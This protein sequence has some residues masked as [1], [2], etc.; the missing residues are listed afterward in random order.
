M[1]LQPNTSSNDV[2]HDTPAHTERGEKPLK[3]FFLFSALLLIE[4]GYILWLRER[5]LLHAGSAWLPEMLLQ[6]PQL[7]GG[8]VVAIVAGHLAWSGL[9]LVLLIFHRRT[10]PAMAFP[11]DPLRNSLTGTV[12]W[13]IVAGANLLLC[14]L[15]LWLEGNFQS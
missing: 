8:L 6:Q 1:E 4:A 15:T 5:H 11:M 7:I 2:S 14:S 3:P 10:G 9:G 12:R 13:T